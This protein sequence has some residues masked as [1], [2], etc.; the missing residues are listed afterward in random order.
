FRT[1]SAISD[2]PKIVYT[3]FLLNVSS[4]IFLITFEVKSVISEGLIITVLPADIAFTRDTKVRLIGKFQGVMIRTNP[5]ASYLIY[6]FD[7]RSVR[8]V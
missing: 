3:S 4:T 8:G 1:F 5:F 7:P 2:P 6:D